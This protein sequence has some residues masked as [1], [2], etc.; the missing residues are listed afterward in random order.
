MSDFERILDECLREIE[1]GR[2]NVDDCLARHP[3][4]TIELS[5]I[6]LAAAR[7]A[8]GRA[9]T[10]AAQ[11]KARA[12]AQLTQHMQTHPRRK[13]SAFH[14]LTSTLRFRPASL[15]VVTLAL[16]L[17][18]LVTGTALA[19]GALP[20]DLLYNWK[21]TSEQV[22]RAAAP[23][24]LEVDLFLIDR[25]AAELIAVS[26]DPA[27]LSNA[28][29]AYQKTLAQ[30]TTVTDA[31]AQARIQAALAAQQELFDRVD[32]SIPELDAYIGVDDLLPAT[33]TPPPA[34]PLIPIPLPPSLPALVPTPEPADIFPIP[35]PALPIPLP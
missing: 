21:L 25:R 9:M 2:A 14:F 22:W 35:V 11:F 33:P 23:D 18:F 24:P 20:G 12:R 16:L 30:L 4:Y 8:E 6:L 13:T 31:A 3:D 10:P 17:V 26:N 32:I 5:P 15:A 29:A 27:R 28:I 19:Q 1:S 7:L 34:P